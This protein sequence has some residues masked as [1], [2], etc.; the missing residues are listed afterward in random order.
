MTES[1]RAWSTWLIA[2]LCLLFQFVVQV[3]PSVMIPSLERDLS[4]SAE[5]LGFLTSSYFISY[6]ICQIPSGWLLDRVGPRLVLT[7]SLV[8]TMGGL[9]WFGMADSLGSAVGSRIALGVFGAPAFPAAALVASRWF[10][11]RRFTLMLGLTESFTLIGGVL[12][13]LGLP[14]LVALTGRTG[15]GWILGGCALALGILSWVLVRDHPSNQPGTSPGRGDSHGSPVESRATRVLIDPRIW[16]A[17]IHGGLFFS[18]IATFGGLWGVPFLHLRLGIESAEA[19]HVLALLFVAGAIGAPLIGLAAS[20][21]RMRGVMLM[22]ASLACTGSAFG[23]VLFTEGSAP[24]YIM[25][26][27][28]GFFSG[29]YALDLAFVIDV[30]SARHQGFAMGMANLILGIVGGPLMITL[31]A[32]AISNSGADPSGSVLDATLDQM[33]VGLS[34]FA[35]GLALLI[36]LGVVLL[37]C[38]RFLKRESADQIQ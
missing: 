22:I 36:P 27:I 32:R 14:S 11:A 10:P 5:E 29:A 18:V 26:I 19:A 28:I 7:G 34:W 31:I 13:D 9:V 23:M 3:Q 6:L 4:L 15:S 30:V 2:S 8:L 17:A 20:R 12:V 25:L 38:N 24:I 1:G 16:L 21:A 33:N 37:F 35:W